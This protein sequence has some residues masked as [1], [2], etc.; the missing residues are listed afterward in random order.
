MR[1]G[2]P[3]RQI[4]RA[5]ILLAAALAAGFVVSSLSLPGLGEAGRRALGIFAVAAILWI[6]EPFPLYVTSFVVVILE[7]VFL[8]RPG[9]PLGLAAGGYAIFM[10]PFFDPVVALFLGGFVLARGVTRYRLDERIARGILSRVGGRPQMV[11]LGM[12][13]TTSALSM[14]I[15]NT[16]TCALMIAVALPVVHSLPENE[17]FRTAILLGIPFAADIGGI[18][19]PIGTPP[20]AIAMGILR[21][22][23]AELGFLDWMARGI[24]VVILLLFVAW[25]L[26]RLLYRPRAASIRLPDAAVPPMDRRSWLVL[27][28]FG[29]VVVLWLTGGLHG[30]PAAAVALLPFVVFFGFG[31][32]D[33]EDLGKLGW[34][35]L[36]IIG[37]G[38]SL[39]VAMRESGLTA[40]IVSQL[41]LSEL[42]TA[43][44]L[45]VLA[46][47]AVAM[48][49]FISNTATANLLLPVV[50]GI[51]AIEPVT[52]AVVVAMS[53]S[54]AM[55]LPISTPSNAIAYGTGLVSVRDMMRAGSIVAVVSATVIVLF[56]RYVF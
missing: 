34:G 50:V 5:A 36:L 38:M 53:A 42:G 29:I 8:G 20:N 44:I 32:L 39:G 27:G 15:S 19:T 51:A 17:P 37:G 47:A 33:R 41:P 49:T 52:S 1:T 11:L 6:A 48:T 43:A 2:S 56:I 13:V 9:G 26:L 7:V 18:G 25:T 35:V 22:T 31:F 28:V 45:F 55:I 16:A 40:W 23:G 4:C 30:V 10:R 54:A 24:P 12:M 21:Q 3:D 46:G 14:W